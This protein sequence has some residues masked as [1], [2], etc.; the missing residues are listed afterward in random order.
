M[1]AAISVDVRGAAIKWSKEELRLSRKRESSGSEFPRSHSGRGRGLLSA[2]F[3][4]A[5][6]GTNV[7]GKVEGGGSRHDMEPVRQEIQ[8]VVGN[9]VDGRAVGEG[10][11]RKANATTSVQRG[12]IIIARQREEGFFLEA[13]GTDATSDL[14]VMSSKK[15]KIEGGWVPGHILRHRFTSPSDVGG[16]CEGGVPRGTARDSCQFSSP[17]VSDSCS[18]P[19]ARCPTPSPRSINK[20][21]TPC[22]THPTVP[23]HRS[24]ETVLDVMAAFGARAL[25]IC[26]ASVVSVALLAGVASAAD[27]P[28]TSPTSAAGTLSPLLG[29]TVLA[30]AL[31][32]GPLRR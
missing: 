30:A 8:R 20:T 31:L 26:I 6:E 9:R 4:S 7:N 16:S 18:L 1:K 29:V 19:A 32:L 13:G 25:V 22:L 15:Q 27:P 12:A 24:Q 2:K 10:E 17:A 3:D 14:L 28:A 5:E 23:H 11:R 21:P